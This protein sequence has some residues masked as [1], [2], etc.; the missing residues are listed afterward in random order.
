MV[1]TA[2]RVSNHHDRV[3]LS[4]ARLACRYLLT[5]D[6]QFT[7]TVASFTAWVKKS[8]NPGSKA[9][10]K[11]PVFFLVLQGRPIDRTSTSEGGRLRTDTYAVLSRY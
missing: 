7:T 3:T 6:R 5:W 1:G 8:S 9:P 11:Q 10:W 4:E 2:N